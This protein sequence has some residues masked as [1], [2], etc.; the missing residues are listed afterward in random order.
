[1][2]N[3]ETIGEE[4][5]FRL[6]GESRIRWRNFGTAKRRF[7]ARAAARVCEVC[8]PAH[9]NTFNPLASTGSRRISPILRAS[10]IAELRN[11]TRPLK[12]KSQSRKVMETVVLKYTLEV[13]DHDGYCSGEECDYVCEKKTVRVEIP[14][15]EAARIETMSR[16]ELARYTGLVPQPKLNESGSYYCRPNKQGKQAGLDRHDFKV[17]IL[18]G[19]R[20]DE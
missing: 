13:S 1:M 5:K 18:K 16:A 12:A 10:E 7:E 14:R 6:S 20:A 2:T 3:I 4:R 17:T 15:E 9:R 11:W 8:N 19:K